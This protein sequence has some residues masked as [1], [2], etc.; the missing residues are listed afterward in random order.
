VAVAHE[1]EKIPGDGEEEEHREQVCLALPGAGVELRQVHEEGGETE[2]SSLVYVGGGVRHALS[3][4]PGGLARAGIRGDVQLLMV[5]GG[6]SF[7]DNITPQLSVTG[8][9]FF[10]F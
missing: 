7:D 3:V 9:V 1:P 10:T 2:R 8:G 4:R 6:L 5:K